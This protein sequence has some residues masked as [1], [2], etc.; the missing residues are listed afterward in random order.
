M[1]WLNHKKLLFSAFV[2]LLFCLFLPSCYPPIAFAKTYTITEAELTQ[3]EQN[4]ARLQA[5]SENKQKQ[6][7]AQSANLKKLEERLTLSLKQN[8]ETQNSLAN[9]EAYLKQYEAE[10]K[11]KQAVKE[12]QR[13]MWIVLAGIATAWA[14]VK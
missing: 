9:A 11:H 13:N 14:C 7:Q 3:L 1:R 6:L 5:S 4:L 2:L 8:E 10:M 12:R